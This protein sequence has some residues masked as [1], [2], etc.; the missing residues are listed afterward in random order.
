MKT[1]AKIDLFELAD[2]NKER[3]EAEYQIIRDKAGQDKLDL[4]ESLRTRVKN[5]WNL[6][7]NMHDRTLAEIL[8]SGKHI[9]VYELKHHQAKQL[10][11]EG[12]LADPG[13]KSAKEEAVRKHLKK[14]YEGRK[15]FDSSIVKGEKAKYAALN[16]GGTGT[17]GY[18]RY[19]MVI[20]REKAEKYKQL[21]FIKEDS[22]V[23]YVDKGC[24]LPDKL[25]RDVANKECVDILAAIKHQNSIETVSSDKWDR[26]V[27]N[28]S[29]NIEAVTLDDILRSHIKCVRIDRTYY[30]EIYLDSLVKIF[31]SELPE[32]D[33]YRLALVKKLLKEL[34]KRGIEL[35][36]IDEN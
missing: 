29:S 8:D 12:K 33:Q 14:F 6:S 27:C 24:L 26:M 17:T 30:N 22:A 15:T 35:E 31:S 7:I 25:S 13:A 11:K 23:N 36:I 9:N 18:G 5:E 19:C 28:D 20:K 2:A 34:K 10:I 1:G 16:I 4:L 3:L 32:A 21:A